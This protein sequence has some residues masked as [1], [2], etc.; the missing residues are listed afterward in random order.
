MD[1]LRL[2][3]KET[4]IKLQLLCSAILSEVEGTPCKS[5]PERAFRGISTTVLFAVFPLRRLNQSIPKPGLIQPI[6]LAPA[7]IEVQRCR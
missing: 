5:V 6:R 7:K 4:L 3:S 1:E 2:C